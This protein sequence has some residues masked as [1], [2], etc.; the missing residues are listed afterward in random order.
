MNPSYKKF[1]FISLSVS[2]SVLFIVFIITFDSQSTID[3][4]KNSNLWIIALALAM[5]AV[6]LFIWALKIKLMCRSL[7]YKIGF[8][9]S[10]R[11]VCA[12]IFA[13]SV[14]PSQIGGEPV[15]IYEIHKAGVPTG[16]A[17]AIVIIERVFDGIILVML[18]FISVII[19]GIFFTHLD[20]PDGWIITAYIAA[21]V[22]TA[23]LILFFIFALNPKISKTV[24]PKIIKPFTKRMPGE[25]AEKFFE[26]LDLN[27]N[28]FHATL[29][30]FSG[31]SKTGTVVGLVFSLFYWLNEF[32]IAYVIIIGLGAEPT[33]KLFVLS[34]VMQIMITV[35]LMIPLTPGSAGVAE[36]S[37]AAF[38]ALIIPSSI[39]GLF[40]II[41]RLIMYYFNLAAGFIA[42][43][44]IVKRDTLDVNKRLS[45]KSSEVKE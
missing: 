26:K 10:F 1:L 13:S 9:H 33:L 24:V 7:G 43:L 35:V 12:N 20:L 31:K 22:F 44:I 28:R 38:Y 15:R 39:V 6:S 3:A 45:E 19:L 14:T 41:W 40:V 18:T 36:I 5:H 29:S 25:K 37:A 8:Y 21:G 4:I 34:L 23:L 27:I 17:T 42:S 2:I 16:D 30:E 32:I 11:M